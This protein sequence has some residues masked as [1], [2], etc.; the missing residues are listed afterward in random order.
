MNMFGI[1]FTDVPWVFNI[2]EF[3]N[4][5]FI[6]WFLKYISIFVIILNLLKMMTIFI[7][8]C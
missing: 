1:F 5:I 2:N 6:I 3:Y 4:K 8:V 7:F